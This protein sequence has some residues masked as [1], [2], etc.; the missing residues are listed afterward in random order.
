MKNIL[1]FSLLLMLTL[2]LS[3]SYVNAQWQPSMGLEGS[4]IGSIIAMDSLLFAT[5]GGNGIFSRT[6][7]SDWEL[8][9]L[10]PSWHLKKRG[11][12]SQ[13]AR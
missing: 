10:N 13:A 6:L 7:N 8:S 9:N 2:F 11:Q 5:C 4:R 3:S 1:Q 12:T